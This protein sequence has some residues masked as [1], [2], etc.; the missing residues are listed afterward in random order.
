VVAFLL[1]SIRRIFPDGPTDP[2][3]RLAWMLMQPIYP[4]LCGNCGE[5]FYFYMPEI[6]EHW[7]EHRKVNDDQA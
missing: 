5:L 4:Y 3:E 1:V 7:N 2:G 6:T